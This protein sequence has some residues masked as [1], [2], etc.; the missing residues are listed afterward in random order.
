MD[1]SLLFQRY[2]AMSCTFY[3]NGL[4]DGKQVVVQ[5]LFCRI[6]LS[7]FIHNDTESYCSSNLT[8]SHQA[9]C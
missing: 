3:L 8:F 7:E 6:L 5:L 4:Y 2:P 9:F 1:L